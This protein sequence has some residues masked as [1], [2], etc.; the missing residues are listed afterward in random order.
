MWLRKDERKLLAFYY[1]KA[2]KTRQNLRF[3]QHVELMKVLGFDENTE[4]GQITE[5]K[6][7]RVLNANEDLKNRGFINLRYENEGLINNVNLTLKGYDLGRKYSSIP[8]TILLCCNEYKVWIILGVI[9]S[10]VGV[11]IAIFKH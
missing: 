2:G 3:E 9:I 10:L 8:H 5:E 6:F 11:L 1:A 7:D 4:S